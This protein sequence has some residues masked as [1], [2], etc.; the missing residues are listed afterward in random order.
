M[1]V[2]FNA[3]TLKK[4]RIC[5][6]SYKLKESKIAL[7]VKLLSILFEFLNNSVI[8]NS[9]CLYIC[10]EQDNSNIAFNEE[11][12]IK[13]FCFNPEIA[14][15]EIIKINPF[16]LILTS[17][18]LKPFDILEKEFQMKFNIVFENDHIINDD[19]IKFTIIKSE[20]C[21]GQIKDFNFDYNNRNKEEMI[22]S[23][24]KIILNLCKLKNNNGGI[25]VFF[26]SYAF[27][28]KCY[29]IWNKFRIDKQIENFK[30]IT[31]DSNSIK[32]LS[33]KIIKS[34]NKNFILLSVYR[35]SSSEGI[36][37]SDDNA[38]IVICVGI[39]YANISD[40][41]IKNKLEYMDKQK[42]KA[43]SRNQ[44]YE[45]DAMINVNQSLGRVI[46]NK[47]DY[48][49]M[50]CIDKRY[51][52][53]SITK[54]FPKWLS[55]NLEIKSLKEND[56]YYKELNDFYSY[57]KSKYSNN[58]KGNNNIQDNFFFNNIINNNINNHLFI[59]ND[60]FNKNELLKKRNR[61]KN[62]DENNL[63]IDNINNNEQEDEES[64][65]IDNTIIDKELLE[66]INKD[67]VFDNEQFQ[68]LQN[69]TNIVYREKINKCPICFTGSNQS[70]FLTYSISKC[71]HI[72]CNICW[73]KILSST[74]ECPLCKR[75]VLLSD[76]KKVFLKK[77]SDNK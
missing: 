47:E 17:G 5:Y 38:R 6:E 43:Y 32:L 11:R 42:N 7:L 15:K 68:K 69:N 13:V 19:Q 49:V 10:N 8:E 59:E 56:D 44:W 23:I 3:L 66:T 14:F 36:D 30:S 46:R 53:N 24:G 77:W 41:K 31:I 21:N 73:N 4:L 27:L 16:A 28:K 52:F 2:I 58:K 9:Y 67:S 63:F 61:D 64:E 29:R 34:E 37:F 39:P 70:I 75:K 54:L 65:S 22:I 72:F 35:G 50:I 51:S 20:E 33:N 26:P 74:K 62:E 55:K 12:K 71:N 18:N 1:A 57:C 40:D 48:E 60:G 25:L 45:A 76:F